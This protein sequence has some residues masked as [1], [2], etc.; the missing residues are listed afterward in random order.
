MSMVGMKM[1]VGCLCVSMCACGHAHVCVHVCACVHPS[2]HPPLLQDC[3]PV[4]LP[5]GGEGRAAQLLRPWP[6]THLDRLVPAAA[7]AGQI[8][9]Q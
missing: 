1:A 3:S 2:A 6:L 7:H 4:Y 9:T 5:A 8:D